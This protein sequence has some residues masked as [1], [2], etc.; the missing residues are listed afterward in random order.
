MLALTN[1]A[2]ATPER[3]CDPALAALDRALEDIAAVVHT[4]SPEVYRARPL[5]EASGSIGEHV[6]RCLDPVAALVSAE[7]S[8]DLSYDK[9]DRGSAVETDPVKALQCI[10]ILRIKVAV[11]RWSMRAQDPIVVTSTISRNGVA[12]TEMSTMARELA[13]VLDHA[14]HHQ[15][16][17]R[18]LAS[19][20]GLDARDR[21]GYAP[22]TP[23]SHVTDR[24]A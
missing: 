17:I 23:R 22:S 13:F 14:V 10:Q 1:R 5:A 6:R 11:G 18:L 2:V 20:Q 8:L 4:L 15:S 21:V 3:T 16:T 7:P 9:G 19:L 24:V 12:V